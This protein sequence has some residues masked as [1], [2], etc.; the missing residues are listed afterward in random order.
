M[1]ILSFIPYVDLFII[2]LIMWNIINLIK[3]WKKESLKK[4]K[5]N[6]DIPNYFFIN[7]CLIIWLI[8]ISI[9]ILIFF[10]NIFVICI[11]LIALF[12]CM[13]KIVKNFNNSPT[14]SNNDNFLY[15]VAS[16]SYVAIFISTAFI[17]L[18]DLIS[19][20]TY[21]TQVILSIIYIIFR[22]VM[23]FNSLTL[24]LF[25]AI[26]NF[27][28][29]NK[30]KWIPLKVN[31]KANTYESKILKINITNI[32]KKIWYFLLLPLIF[33]YDIIN[34]VIIE[35]KLIN[36]KL[37][38]KEILVKI[39]E[40]RNKHITILLLLF[41]IVSLI[42]TYIIITIEDSLFNDKTKDIFGLITTVVAI[43]LMIDLIK[44]INFKSKN[45]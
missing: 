25:L 15:L 26:Y 2:F 7:T 18:L 39:N 40:N 41:I 31:K 17:N 10:L 24:N 30:N 3:S 4:D 6:T 8:V 21:T 19:K 29:S 45:N 9:I 33:L 43:P 34:Y 11:Y 38:I 36:I 20:F 42:I 27:N 37:K 32:L 23:C 35:K 16:I 1:F 13:L 5:I 12:I 14:L 28:E 44:V 22:I